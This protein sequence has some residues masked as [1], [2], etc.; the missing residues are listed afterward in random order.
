[1]I[2]RLVLS[3]DTIAKRRTFGRRI[4]QPQGLGP[5]PV[6]EGVRGGHLQV[7][8]LP[9]AG[10]NGDVQRESAGTSRRFVC[11]RIFDLV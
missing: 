1:M 5:D 2:D 7:V 8:R 6:P 11:F 4:G 10:Q 3:T 9:F